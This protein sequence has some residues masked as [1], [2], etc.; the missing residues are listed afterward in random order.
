MI[1]GLVVTPSPVNVGSVSKSS[2]DCRTK[3]SDF[4]IT[5]FDATPLANDGVPTYDRV[6]DA[7]SILDD[8][9]LQND[10]VSDANASANFHILGNSDC[11]ANL[12][13][14]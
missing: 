8:N 12:Y 13:Y 11:G 10:G 1:S 3:N 2:I 7:G 6:D 5:S 4:P 14:Q 9:T